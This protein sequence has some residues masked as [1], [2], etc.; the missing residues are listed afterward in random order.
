MTTATT[1]A[2]SPPSAFHR[3]S[4]RLM[5]P[6]LLPNLTKPLPP[7]PRPRPVF[8]IGDDRPPLS[9][10]DSKHYRALLELLSTEL[11]Y[12][13]DLRILVSVCFVCRVCSYLIS[14]VR[15]VYLR[16]LP[17]LTTAHTASPSNS[18]LAHF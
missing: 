9:S 7:I 4:S 8:H 3:S 5:S 18:S 16:S 11:G 10:D 17:F 14:P 2:T 12:L 1:T 6:S 15:Q 13:L